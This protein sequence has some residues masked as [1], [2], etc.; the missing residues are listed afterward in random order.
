MNP[1]T[2]IISMSMEE[3]HPIF[4]KK[5]VNFAPTD[6]IL[7]MSVSNEL[8]VLAMANN[9]LLRIDLK[10]K[11]E[12]EEIELIKPSPQLRLSGLYLDPTGDHLLMSLVPGAI[13]NN[14][15]AE[16]LYLNRKSTK[17]KQTSKFRGLEITAVGW[18]QTGQKNDSTTKPFLLGT[19]KGLI[20]ET[21]ISGDSD[22][23]FQTSIEQYWRQVFDIGK[24]EN[25]PIT[26]LEFHRFPGSER[27]VI[28]VATPDR[29]YSFV[30]NISNTEERPLL[31]QIFNFYLSVPESFLEIP[32]NIKYSK[33]QLFYSTPKTLPIMFAWLTGP[34]IFYGQLNTNSEEGS[35]FENSQLLHYPHPTNIPLSFVSTE[36]HVLLLYSDHVTAIST[37]SQKIVFEDSYDETF[38][39][40]VNIFKD[41]VK[42]TVWMFSERAVFR[43]IINKEERNVWQI[44]MEN[45][46]FELAKKYCFENLAHLDRVL[47]K[48]A[49]VCFEKEE[50]E[51]SA[52]RYAETQSSFEEIALKFLQVW[53]IQA[54]KIFLKKKLERLKPQDKTQM[55]MIVLWVVE[56]FQNQLGVLRN[57]GKEHSIEYINLQKEMDDFLAMPQVKTCVT[58][59]KDTVYSLMASHGDKENLI[60]LTIANKDFERVIRHHI[61]KGDF[62]RALEVLT[63]QNEKE[64]YY[65]FAPALIQAVP[66]E[67]VD[68][69]IEQG[70]TLNACK[71]LPALISCHN[72]DSQANEIIRYLEF[73]TS[74][75]CQ[76]QAVHNYLL[77]LYAQQTDKPERLM[78]YLELQGQELSMVNYDVHYALRL[79]RE[80]GLKKACVQLSAL[81]G[82]WEAAVDLALTIDVPLAKQ[83]ACMPQ[84]DDELTKKLWLKIA[85]HVVSEKNDIKQAMEFLQ[86]CDLIKI[87]DILPFFSDFVTIDHFKDAIC[88]SLQEY[89]Q[90]IQDLKEETDEATQSA[91]VIRNDIVAFR[92]R[93]MIIEPSNVCCI[94]DL[95]LL[96]RP[97][98]VFPCS[99]K[100]HFDCLIAE[101]SPLLPLDV[102]ETLNELQRQ[103]PSANG[104]L[105]SISVGSATLSPREQIK[106]DIN[107]IVASECLY[108][109]DYM[110]RAINQ[111]F[112]ADK[113][114]DRILKE[115]E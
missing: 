78:R 100:F 55:T 5:K 28:I 61:H 2:G 93:F 73:V 59:N 17:I 34:G 82:L 47:T 48:Q 43:Y 88:T 6:R 71:L 77:S 74:H 21:E 110:I 79:C 83:I 98:Y 13:E 108:C 19:S 1:T 64:L 45:G 37:L 25:R 60:K 57:E 23:I 26:G 24:G 76:D 69:L 9:M 16:L 63:N 104:T 68:A 107:S 72:D 11:S 113:D 10:N 112:I 49:E 67:M 102:R 29:V 40:L 46:E 56:L 91:E 31:Q 96:L 39:K 32:S 4:A 87:E 84:A 109:G 50:Y 27:Y 90:H 95:Q 105:D 111:P 18:N 89:N 75:N 53:Q 92:N 38:G 115:W 14:V 7:H 22:R 66:R 44:Y 103:L 99:H 15:Q 30:G 35:M 101:L 41:P 36:F 62:F 80:K 81:L 42:G 58:R 3:E 85:Q 20:L 65:T 70:T 114:Y 97:F 12:P 94:C 33:L 54:L 51:E 52:A 86:E 106:N 8:A